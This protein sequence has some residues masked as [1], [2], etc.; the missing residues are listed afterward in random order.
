MPS[1]VNPNFKVTWVDHDGNKRGPYSRV[2]T[3]SGFLDLENSFNELPC[4][5]RDRFTP[6]IGQIKKEFLEI[7][8]NE[9]ST[10]KSELVFPGR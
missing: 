8:G 9:G 4:Y 10:T 1:F 2:F 3:L 5:L 6:L 7:K